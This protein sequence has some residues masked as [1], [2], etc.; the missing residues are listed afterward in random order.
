VF[1]GL[2]VVNL[3]VTGPFPAPADDREP[4]VRVLAEIEGPRPAEATQP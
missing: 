1:L 4:G 3:L 2:V